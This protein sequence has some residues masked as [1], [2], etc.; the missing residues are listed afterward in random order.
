MTEILIV[1]AGL[2][3][4]TYARELAEAGWRVDVIDR[5]PHVAGNAFDLVDGTG[6]R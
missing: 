1:G 6:V 2:A 4:A 5:R 3:G